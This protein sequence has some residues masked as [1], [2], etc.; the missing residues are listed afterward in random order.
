MPRRGWNS[1]SYWIALGTCILG[2]WPLW[3]LSSCTIKRRKKG[4]RQKER[5]EGRG[6]R[7]DRGR[8]AKTEKFQ[9]SPDHSLAS[10][11]SF[12]ANGDIFPLPKGTARRGS[13]PSKLQGLPSPGFPRAS[14]PELKGFIVVYCL[15]QQWFGG[16]SLPQRS[17]SLLAPDFP[18][19]KIIWGS[20]AGFL[21]Y[22]MSPL[23]LFIL[24][25][26]FKSSY[27]LKFYYCL[28]Q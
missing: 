11:Q 4:E 6:R 3:N 27:F 25:D 17:H 5:E 22:E 2:A 19:L 26:S 21:S 15:T 20:P 8:G 24:Y 7:G 16:N 9:N 1:F 18:R 12:W 23:L 14:S 10:Q 13:E 28:R